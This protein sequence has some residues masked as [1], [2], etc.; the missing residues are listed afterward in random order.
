MSEIET[1]ETT[2]VFRMCLTRFFPDFLYALTRIV[3][4]GTI[5]NEAEDGRTIVASA[6]RHS[7]MNEDSLLFL[8]HTESAQIV[9]TASALFE[10]DRVIV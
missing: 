5:Q 3:K 2:I 10:Y 7:A 8:G 6:A 1:I 4:Q 9:N